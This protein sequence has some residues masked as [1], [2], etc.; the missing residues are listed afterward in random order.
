MKTGICIAVLIC[1]SV[2]YSCKKDENNPSGPAA[3]VSS[4][5][6]LLTSHYWRY[7][8]G[9]GTEIRDTSGDGIPDTAY[10][11]ITPDSC[12][13]DDRFYFRTN[14]L[15]IKDPY[16]VSC[17][18]FMDTMTWSWTSDSTVIILDSD[19]SKIINL[20]STQLKLGYAFTIA[21]PYEFIRDTI[22]MVYP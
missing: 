19:P 17:S 5:S 10:Y 14:G 13:A 12:L 9:S 4:V 2:F 7:Y 8:H 11:S 18:N 1:I 6:S 20:T 16:L 15:F 22:L 21:S 3:S